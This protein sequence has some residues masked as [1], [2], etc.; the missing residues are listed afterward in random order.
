MSAS[1][2]VVAVAA[3]VPPP[4]YSAAG[5]AGKPRDEHRLAYVVMVLLGAG[6]LLPYNTLIVAVD[7]LDNTYPGANLEFYIPIAMN[8]LSPVLQL[9]MVR[10]GHRMSFTRRV[11][12]W[13]TFESALIVAFPLFQGHLAHD[14][15]LGLTV[16]CV[17]LLGIGT[18]ILQSTV[19]GFAAFLPAEYT[20]AVMSGNGVAGLGVSLL[21][22]VTKASFPSSHQG[23]RRSSLIFF[24]ISAFTTFLCAVGYVYLVRLP[25]TRYYMERSGNP[26]LTPKRAVSSESSG[27]VSAAGT[28]GT[29]GGVPSGGAL[30][31]SAT[32]HQFVGARV[33]GEAEALL[34]T[35]MVDDD[36]RAPVVYA[37]L[38]PKI[39]TMAGVVFAVFFCTFLIF[40][41]LISKLPSS[42]GLRDGWL[43]II[44]IT[45][46]NLFDL[47]GRSLPG[48]GVQLP[49]RLAVPPT[50]ARFILFPLFVL[51]A[52]PRVFASDVWAYAFM[53]VLALSNGHLASVAMM[54]A[55]SLVS[56]DER[57]A[58]GYIMSFFLN[59]GIVAGSAAGL[60]LHH[61]SVGV[62]DHP[63]S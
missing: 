43:A 48:W 16:L 26:Y 32:F 6:L 46:F 38:V 56:D 23:V 31:R 14:T 25:F 11:V 35:A 45:E 61:F 22:I 1:E 29:P 5:D 24:A 20:Q 59:L 2:R 8:G 36:E 37:T 4:G 39:R 62:P 12:F 53:A 47:I 7:F 55:P 30:E 3:P 41:G 13:F 27:S 51:C 9:L 52:H 18:A 57:E 54:T 63:A 58:A 17:V 42:Y 60:L 21:R 44:L 40:P 15:G 33:G 19:F 34:A 28:N 10:Y 50:A 49:A